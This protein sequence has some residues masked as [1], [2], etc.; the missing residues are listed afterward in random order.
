MQTKCPRLATL[1]QVFLIDFS[2]SFEYKK[3]STP[4]LFRDAKNRTQAA[5][6]ARRGE[7]ASVCECVSVSVYVSVVGKTNDGE[8]SN[9]NYVMCKVCDSVK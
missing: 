7:C 2:M 4:S 3:T 8:M 5:A 9:G 1:D 6:G